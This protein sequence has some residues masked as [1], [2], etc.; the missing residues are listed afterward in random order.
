MVEYLRSRVDEGTRAWRKAPLTV[1][2][3]LLQEAESTSRLAK[4]RWCEG[5]GIQVMSIQHDGIMVKIGKDRHEEIR[6]GM[7]QRASMACGY[8]V[9]VVV[10]ETVEIDPPVKEASQ[11]EWL[12]RN[13]LRAQSGD[14]SE[15]EELAEMLQEVLSGKFDYI[16]EK[17]TDVGREA[18]GS[19]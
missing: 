19:T 7:S 3:Y 13:T 18:Y 16:V 9:E 10:K 17:H 14:E 11:E 15:D 5:R 12:A 1:K 4:V 8:E 2:S 6:D